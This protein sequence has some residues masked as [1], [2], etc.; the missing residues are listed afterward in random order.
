MFF[1]SELGGY[2]GSI[3]PVIRIHGAGYGESSW[4]TRAAVGYLLVHRLQNS[5]RV[6]ARRE[7]A[8][9]QEPVRQRK[10]GVCKGKVVSDLWCN[11]LLRTRI[12]RVLLLIRRKS[13]DDCRVEMKEPA[14]DAGPFSQVH[15]LPG[16]DGSFQNG[17][18]VALWWY[19][20]EV[21][22]FLLRIQKWESNDYSC[23]QQ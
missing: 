17:T 13:T 3:L 5:G 18:N 1:S 4:H 16:G 12:F 7:V 11:L 8:A 21:I 15:R 14:G 6:Q 23:Y 22:Y 2:D 20:F 19:V 10:L 9:V